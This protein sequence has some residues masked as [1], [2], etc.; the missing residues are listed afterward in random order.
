MRPSGSPLG[1]GAMPSTTCGWCGRLSNMTPTGG[2]AVIELGY[3]RGATVMG[4]YK[5]DHCQHLLVASCHSEGIPRRDEG[6]S[7]LDVMDPSIEWQPRTGVLKEFPDVP[8]PIGSAASEVHACLSIG[9]VR[10]AVALARAVVEATAKHNGIT[11]G[12]LEQKI[13]GLRAAGL[14]SEGVRAAAHEVRLDGNE[15]AHGDLV[16]EPI[17]VE[18]AEDVVALLDEVLHSVY[19]SPARVAR[20][21]AR[22]LARRESPPPP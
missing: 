2:S 11:K 9:A 5:C 6:Y 20:V 21:N 19:Q 3:M 12:T 8:E 13:D 4:S 22:R 14:V 10:A 17:S 18:E 16:A 15:V 7:T 1:C